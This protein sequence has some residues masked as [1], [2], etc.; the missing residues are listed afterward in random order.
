MTPFPS[1]NLYGNDFR[2]QLVPHV[3]K[4]LSVIPGALSNRLQK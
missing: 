2:P 3:R 4:S 1:K